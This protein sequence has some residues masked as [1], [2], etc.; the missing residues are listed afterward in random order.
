MVFSDQHI[1]HTMNAT[2][3]PNAR[4]HDFAAVYRGD[5]WSDGDAE[6][7]VLADDITADPLARPHRRGHLDADRSP[8]S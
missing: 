1:D 4:F 7:R 5:L 6:G 2:L 8:T 3:F